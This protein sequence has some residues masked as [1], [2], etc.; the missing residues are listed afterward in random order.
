MAA[1]PNGFLAR[2]GRL[3]PSDIALLAEAVVEL[4]VSAAAI[5][6]LSFQ[7]VGRIASPPL[8]RAR[9]AA[10]PPRIAWAVRAAA[11]RVPWRTVCFQQGLATQIMLRRRGVD[12]TLWF[13]ASPKAATGLAAH[14]W[15]TADGR[16]VIGGEEAV[17]F[18]VLARF[19]PAGGDRAPAAA[20]R[21]FDAG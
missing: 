9:P 8:G 14:V 1:R 15:V 17:G 7:R 5:R 6:L 3:S 4:A 2:L 16:D 19:P 11:R 18:A 13:G 10:K 12:A 20:P 21:R